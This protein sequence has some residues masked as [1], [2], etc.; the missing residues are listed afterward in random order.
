MKMGFTKLFM[1]V[2]IGTAVAP[3][4]VFAQSCES[5][6]AGEN[7]ST[8]VKLHFSR[9]RVSSNDFLLTSAEVDLE[10][11]NPSVTFTRDPRPVSRAQVPELANLLGKIMVSVSRGHDSGRV[12]LSISPLANGNWM[13]VA[14]GVSQEWT[15]QVADRIKAQTEMLRS[16]AI[17]LGHHAHSE[18]L[19]LLDENGQVRVV[20]N[21]TATLLNLVPSSSVGRL[22]VNTSPFIFYGKHGYPAFEKTLAVV[23]GTWDQR[24]PLSDFAPVGS[25]NRFGTLIEHA[26]RLAGRKLSGIAVNVKRVLSKPLEVAT[27][28]EFSGEVLSV[29]NTNSGGM[30][31][32]WFADIKTPQGILKVN[33]TEARGL[34]VARTQASMDALLSGHEQEAARARRQA[35]ERE[36]VVHEARPVPAA[37]TQTQHQRLLKRLNKLNQQD[38]ASLLALRERIYRML[39][40]SPESDTAGGIK[41]LKR[42]AE[43]KTPRP[44][45]K[46]KEESLRPLIEEVQRMLYDTEGPY[47]F[48]N[49]ISDFA[50]EVFLD[51]MD[52]RPLPTGTRRVFLRDAHEN[53]PFAEGMWGMSFEHHELK[54]FPVIEEEDLMPAIDRRIH[55]YGFDVGISNVP[56]LRFA[57]KSQYL[58][59]LQG[60]NLEETT[61]FFK[62]YSMQNLLFQDAYFTG[63]PHGQYSHIF[64]WLYLAERLSH[65]KMN[66]LHANLLNPLMRLQPY[67]MDDFATGVRVTDFVGQRAP[68]N[69]DYINATLQLL[70]PVQ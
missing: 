36:F 55:L 68:Q 53:Y 6:F 60:L 30:D 67:F 7:I 41:F 66:S 17:T 32:V 63:K 45:M 38:R 9:E 42:T 62:Q 47:G 11:A 2:F 50:L 64:Q 34:R 15:I 59:T 31:P 69:P 18:V 51:V 3:I 35:K 12:A 52:L 65:P 58:A 43:D 27:I 70:F 40:G 21:E 20:V 8:D 37:L 10:L 26:Q 49:F 57:P 25:E 23:R 16:L 29:E 39:S 48:S 61:L 54:N 22:Q 4:G 56:G 1:G 24:F 19:A 5:V 14:R 28:Q 13:I 44:L 46:L 33:L